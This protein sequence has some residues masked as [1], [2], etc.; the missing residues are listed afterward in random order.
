MANAR[1]RVS[2]ATA[3]LQLARAEALPYPTGTFDAVVSVNVLCSVASLDEAL[4]ELRRVLK[5][6]GQLRLIEHVK[7]D[8][9][10]PGLFMDLC[11]PVWLA[12][13]GAGCN[14]NRDLT[15]ALQRAGFTVMEIKEFQL[16]S[17]TFPAAYPYRWI[18]AVRS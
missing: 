17:K 16:F 3:S 10:V 12:L 5:P 2:A 11:N 1:A 13:N 4:A 15:P 18:K 7:S 9:F 14:W 6:Q 8:R